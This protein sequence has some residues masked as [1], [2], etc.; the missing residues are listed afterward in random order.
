M[1]LRVG[2]LRGA[3]YGNEPVKPVFFRLNFGDVDREV[4]DGIGLE[5]F[6][7]W[8]IP[9]NLR[10]SRYAMSLQ[11]VVK[12]RPGQTRNGGLQGVEAITQ[13]QQRI[14]TKGSNNDSLLFLRKNR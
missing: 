1:E 8:F 13:R 7:L 14:G 2:K 12:V 11:A 9:F 5:I 3:I 4:A 6:L 10:Q